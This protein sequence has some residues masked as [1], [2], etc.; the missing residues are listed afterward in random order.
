MTPKAKPVEA[1]AVKA[2][3]GIGYIIARTRREAMERFLFDGTYASLFED[4]WKYYYQKGYRCVRVRVE[5][6]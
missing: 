6:A 4:D 1:W 5:E 2:P 3:Q